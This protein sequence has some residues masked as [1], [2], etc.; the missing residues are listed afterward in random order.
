MD[1]LNLRETQQVFLS[2]GYRSTGEWKYANRN[3]TLVTVSFDRPD[4]LQQVFNASALLDDLTEQFIKGKMTRNE[5]NQALEAIMEKG[6]VV[7]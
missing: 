4:P 2:Q 1:V 6:G 5:A 7:C 3:E